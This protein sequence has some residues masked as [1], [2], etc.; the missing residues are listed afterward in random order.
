MFPRKNSD[1]TLAID[2][3][4]DAVRSV[5]VRGRKGRSAVRSFA[6]RALAEGPAATLPERQL[7]VLGELLLRERIRRGRRS[8]A[9]PTSMVLTRTVALDRTKS[10]STE[11]QILWTLQNCLPFDPR[12]LVFDY[13]A[14]GGMG[15]RGRQR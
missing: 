3:G 1:T 2:L 15:I 9:L 7:E 14:I 13:W 4:M 10:Q 6:D 12:D 8:S 5:E 11:E